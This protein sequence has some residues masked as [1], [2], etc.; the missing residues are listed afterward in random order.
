MATIQERVNSILESLRIDEG[1]LTT[2]KNKKSILSVTPKYEVSMYSD[3]K[4]DR[5]ST[6]VLDGANFNIKEGMNH[7][8]S[9]FDTYVVFAYKDV[10]N[11]MYQEGYV[12]KFKST[13]DARVF[14]DNMADRGDLRILK[15]TKLVGVCL[16]SLREKKFMSV[17]SA[18]EDLANGYVRDALSALDKYI[19]T[20]AIP[21]EVEEV[22]YEYSVIGTVKLYKR[23]YNCSLNIKIK[24]KD[25]IDRDTFKTLTNAIDRYVNM[26]AISGMYNASSFDDYI[27][28]HSYLCN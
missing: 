20:N 23:G 15:G 13:E 16:Y 7:Y 11:L 2:A 25:S 3:V 4:N 5:V 12:Y 17:L 10:G 22:L 28:I 24:T 1:M 18:V 27:T 14:Y 21:F 9:I 6:K 26:G 8:Y 19:E